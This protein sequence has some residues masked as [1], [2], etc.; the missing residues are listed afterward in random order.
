MSERTWLVQRESGEPASRATTNDLIRALLDERID[1]A[2]L[3]RPEDGSADWRELRTIDAFRIASKALRASEK[4]RVAPSPSVAPVSQDDD[5]EVRTRYFTMGATSEP[6]G[7]GAPAV[8]AA[9]SDDDDEEV[10]TKFFTA[11]A[12][13]SVTTPQQAA[14]R[15]STQPRRPAAPPMRGGSQ[16]LGVSAPPAPPVRPA[17]PAPKP[18]VVTDDDDDV[19]TKYF[20]SGGEPVRA[21][22]PA[23]PAAPAASAASAAPW[24]PP[25]PLVVS[26]PQPLETTQTDLRVPPP[27]GQAAPPNAYGQPLHQRTVNMPNAML[28]TAIV[29]PKPDVPRAQPSN[30]LNSTLIL[31]IAALFAFVCALAAAST[32]AYVFLTSPP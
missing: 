30:R 11:D 20:T 23:A 6:A 10:K 8:S 16:P 2:A 12:P 21:V 28:A 22:A 5:D 13:A 4:R 24:Q 25:A 15:P 26:S 31:V 32:V 3:V 27:F 19:K 17:V 14:P 1:P 9:V 18:V 29:A 7:R